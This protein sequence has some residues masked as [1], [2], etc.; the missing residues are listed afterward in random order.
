MKNGGRTIKHY[1]KEAKKRMRE[2]FWDEYR[3]YRDNLKRVALSE[4]KSIESS[5]AHHKQ[6]TAQRIYDYENYIN[7]EAFYKKVCAIMEST[8]IITNPIILLAD[9]D[10]L[11]T[12]EPN[13]LQAYLLS[14]SNRY[15]KMRTRYYKEHSGIF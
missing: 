12:L 5:L 6:L 4:G 9:K 15:E 13:A 3:D 7:D 2:G 8:E 1:A 14:V 10:K 11:E